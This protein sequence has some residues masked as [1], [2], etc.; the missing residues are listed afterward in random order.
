MK[1]RRGT[2]TAW[3]YVLG[4]AIMIFSF[5]ICSALGKPEYTRAC[6]LLGCVA[7]N[8]L[9]VQFGDYG[10]KAWFCAV[11]TIAVAAQIPIVTAYNAQIVR[12]SPVVTIPVAILDGLVIV[13]IVVLIRTKL[14]ESAR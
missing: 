2:G 8:V 10:R 14:D 6:G 11:L 9:L 1:K 3:N 4:G 13:T 5:V 12:A 7:A